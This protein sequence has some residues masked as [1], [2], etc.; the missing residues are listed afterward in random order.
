MDAEQDDAALAARI[1]GGGDPQ[2]EEQLARAWFPRV[3]AWSRLHARDADAAADL[4]QEE[5]IVVLAALRERR[6]T[7]TGRLPAYVLGVCRNVARDWSKGQRRRGALLERFGSE[8]AQAIPPA[9]SVEKA[10]LA[11]CLQRLTPR[12]RAVVT[13]TY[14]ADRDGDEIGHALEMTPGNVRVV[15]HRALQQLL[16]CLGRQP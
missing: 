3:R 14:Y 13:L 15:R 1:A 5:L 8:W 7:E 10:K 9:A 4:A 12:E 16:D 11:Q 6:V 2:A